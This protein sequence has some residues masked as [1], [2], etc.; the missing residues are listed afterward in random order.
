VGQGAGSEGA[1][2]LS[3]SKTNIVDFDGASEDYHFTF[4][5]KDDCERAMDLF[6]KMT[7]HIDG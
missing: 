7:A 1:R 2:A 3:I 4:M 5:S 6:Q